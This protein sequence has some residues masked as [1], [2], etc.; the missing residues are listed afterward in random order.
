M[1]V[2]RYVGSLRGVI[3]DPEGERMNQVKRY[4]I[5]GLIVAVG[6]AVIVVVRQICKNRKT[7]ERLSK[8]KESLDKKFS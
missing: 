8:I 6:V 2:C 3:Q 5:M 1:E 7:I 4:L